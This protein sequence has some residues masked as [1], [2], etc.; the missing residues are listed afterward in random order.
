MDIATSRPHRQLALASSLLILALALLITPAV[1]MAQGLEPGDEQITG[2]VVLGEEVA[3]P[4]LVQVQVSPA[5]PKVGIVRF[6]V[7]VRNLET[8]EDIDDAIVRIFGTPSERGEKQYS[9]ALNSP[10]DPIFYLSQLD[11]EESGIWAVDVEVE[12]SLGTGSTVLSIRVSPP[13]RGA[14]ANVWGSALYL[15]VTL[16]FIGGA[17]WLW[18]SSKKARQR[19][20]S[21]MPQESRKSQKL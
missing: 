15:L 21:R 10:F 6:A 17:T 13:S 11:F 4:H 5:A 14:T 18:Y 20:R 8:G 16:A 7:R 2:Y 3:G 1:V 19:Q 9:P 12:S